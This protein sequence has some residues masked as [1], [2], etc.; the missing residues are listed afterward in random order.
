MTSLDELFANIKAANEIKLE[1]N[2]ERTIKLKN[3]TDPDFDPCKH[4]PGAVGHQRRGQNVLEVTFKTAEEAEEAAEK[5]T[6]EDGVKIIGPKTTLRQQRTSRKFCPW[7][8]MKDIKVALRRQIKFLKPQVLAMPDDGPVKA[9]FSRE[10]A[11]QESLMIFL[12]HKNTNKFLKD[13][14]DYFQNFKKGQKVDIIRN[15]R[16]ELKEDIQGII[17]I[18]RGHSAESGLPLSRVKLAKHIRSL[19]ENVIKYVQGEQSTTPLEKIV[20]KESSKRRQKSQKKDASSTS[21]G[22]T[23]TKKRKTVPQKAKRYFE[24]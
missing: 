21:T 8:S 2:K 5:G 16:H 12:H 1:P 6:V 10:L 22:T 15:V 3:V 24:K 13:N 4:F 18:L 9:V 7:K 11:F 23:A 14:E 20:K 19:A 17:E